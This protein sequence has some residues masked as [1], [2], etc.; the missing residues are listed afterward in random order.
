[1]GASAG[2]QIQ[3]K[4]ELQMAERQ[5]AFTLVPSPTHNLEGHPENAQRFAGLTSLGEA[6][7]GASLLEIR[8]EP[9]PRQAVEE[10]H[11][12]AYLDALQQACAQGPG[13]VDYAPTYVTP[14]SYE[15]ALAAAG[16]TL[17][18]LQSLVDD[19]AD[20]AFA[21]VRPPG[22]HATATRAMG[23]CLLNNIAIAA[24]HAQIAGRERV[25]IVDFDVHHGNGTQ[26]I[27]EGDP[28]VLYI[29]THQE[30]I[31]PGTGFADETGLGPGEGSVINIPLPARSGDVAL[32]E[33]FRRIVLP[34]GE[35]F[36]PDIIL[37]SAGFDAHWRDPLAELQIS[38]LGYHELTALLVSLAERTCRKLMLVLEGGYDREALAGSVRAV[39]HALAGDPPRQDPLGP[40]PF[41]EP[42]ID[43]R[44]ARALE[45][46]DL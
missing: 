1:M 28:Q 19:E 2:F 15:S 38:C 31:Y 8:S 11:S 5:I 17:Q 36:R 42:D 4:G 27:F 7:I 35:R 43:G 13:Y 16:G 14:S 41:P 40:A 34:A 10:V 22:H 44:I 25:M 32:A 26:D 24:R 23:F 33:I 45:I 6:E 39:M 29:S 21:L 37:V 20:R 30:G 9:A 46:H 12:A 3:P 18:V